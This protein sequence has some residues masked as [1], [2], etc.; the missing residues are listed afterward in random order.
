MI[1]KMKH[2][3]H[4]TKKIEFSALIFDRS[5]EHKKLVS[6][7]HSIKHSL[8]WVVHEFLVDQK[9]ICFFFKKYLKEYQLKVLN[10]ELQMQ[11]QNQ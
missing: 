4:L 8:I 1:I 6:K 9:D 2:W 11:K 5:F 7:P 3:N 10:L